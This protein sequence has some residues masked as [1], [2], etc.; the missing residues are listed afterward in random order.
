MSSIQKLFTSRDNQTD[1]VD[2]QTGNI[3]NTY[4]GQLDRLW[5]N[6]DTNAFYYSDGNTP[7]GIPVGGGGGG[8]GSPS[9]PTNSVQYNAGG[10]NFGGSANLT[11][12]P[13]T[14]QLIS[15]SFSSVGNIT[16]ANLLGSAVSASGNITG[17]NIL[18]DG[19]VSATGNVAGNYIL[20]N[21]AFLTGI[22]ASVSNI[23]NGTS[24]VSVVSSGG[25]VAIG[26]GG[27]SNV[28]VFATTGEY[29][30]GLLS[31]SGNVIGGNI[32]TAG[33]ISATG[34]VTGDYFIG[35]G[36]Q[37]T[38]V[39][40][41]SVNANAL[42]GNTL[43][44]NVLYSSLTQ[45]GNLANLSVVG[46]TVSGNL[47]T[48]GLITASGNIQGNN[49]FATGFASVTGNV[50]AGNVN[51]SDIRPTTGELTISTATGNLNLQSAGNI[52]LANTFV[53][54]VAYP[55]Q[56]ADAAS[57]L[58]V[59]T[60]ASTG[61][62]Y[63]TPAYA[64]T[65]TT[66]ATAT[67]GTITYTQPNGVSN[68]VGAYLSTTG[69]FNLIDT[70]NVQTVGTRILVKNEGNSTYNGVY[71]WSNAT[72][73]VR[74]TDTNTYGTV[75]NTLSLNDYFFVTNGNVNAGSSFVV[76]S[77]P[78]TITFGTSNIT[79]AL[80]GQATTY[81]ANVDAGLSLVGTQFNA[82]VDQNTTAFDGTGNI[83]VKAGA[84]LTTPN[85]GAAT[86]TSLNLT[87][88]VNSGNVNTGGLI[89]AT[90]N[91]IVGNVN[92][93]GLITVAGN[94]TGG[95]LLTGG[96]V[97]ATGNI[98]GYDL[99][100][101]NLKISATVRN[102]FDMTEIAGLSYNINLLAPAGYQVSQASGTYSQLYWTSNIANVDTI[103]GNDQYVWAYV[104]SGGFVVAD[105][106]GSSYG[107]SWIK[108]TDRLQANNIS[109]Y[110]LMS[111]GGNIIGGNVLF[112]GGIVSGTG[113]IYSGNLLTSGVISAT[114]NITGNNVF[115]SFG[116][117]Q[118]STD[119]NLV[120]LTQALIA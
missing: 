69:S 18:T 32:I 84:N 8:N 1:E 47:L 108:A 33:Q 94:I 114:G 66:L 48:A 25:N 54:S 7:G 55:V 93:A 97:S 102:G 95:N 9:G 17:G 26:I 57:K 111:V 72:A 28:A 74:S 10:G 73:I 78:G 62:T 36:S 80:F 88:N 79:F 107:L 22:T 61:I 104:S 24:N 2:S 43:S 6:P 81:T 40:A 113:N 42:V 20:G 71:T 91:I 105:N 76:N 16:G 56:D 27:T 112:D 87:G 12:N 106:N 52:V 37:L 89:S 41:S 77:P 53:N 75:P 21:G 30:T 99:N 38:G 98:T 63:H 39:A 46:N 85:I 86:G 83:I 90:G 103:G 92:T 68:G 115:V 101:A 3:G 117:T 35:N 19:Q 45:V 65:T 49:I 44:S 64:A 15:A 120:A 11:F 34:N 118:A 58:Y 119:I 29:I 67:G 5:W 23:N 14:G 13:T 109:A 110:G 70:A 59:D 31:A 96:L 60:I 82:K 116:P 51:T 4:V 100:L 50:I